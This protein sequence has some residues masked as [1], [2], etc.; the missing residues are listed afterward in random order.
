MNPKSVSRARLFN[1]I[2]SNSDRRCRSLPPSAPIEY[3]FAH[4]NPAPPRQPYINVWKAPILEAKPS[5]APAGPPKPVQA[6]LPKP[7]G[8]PPSV[9]VKL[10]TSSSRPPHYTPGYSDR[11]PTYLGNYVQPPGSLQAPPPPPS[12]I[13]PA[14]YPP[15]KIHQYG[16]QPILPAN[17]ALP[18]QSVSLQ[19][20]YIGLQSGPQVAFSP[21]Q[22]YEGESGREDPAST[23]R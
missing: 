15:L 5:A 1:L 13:G 7:P 12:S 16:S 10:K 19:N 14:P 2:T 17:M 9:P 21:T 23:R 8:P 6:T 20:P 11:A 22:Q 3:G 4:Y 18:P